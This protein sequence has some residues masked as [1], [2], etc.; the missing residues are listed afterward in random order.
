M[1]ARGRW[2]D[3]HIK[4]LRDYYGR[5][6]VSWIASQ[7]GRTPECVHRQAAKQF[8]GRGVAWEPCDDA[9]LRE[10]LMHRASRLEIARR[11]SVSEEE[12]D[13]RIEAL[14]AVAQSHPLRAADEEDFKRCYSSVLDRDLVIVFGVVEARIAEAASRLQLRKNKGLMAQF[15][16]R[17]VMPRWAAAELAILRVDYATCSNISIARKLGRSVKSV[18]S[19]A[20]HLGLQKS[21]E[22]LREMGAQN[23][24]RRYE[25]GA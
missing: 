6:A 4:F 13:R 18:V 9:V 21:P 10:G 2:A 20:H 22:R 25:R 16:V 15:G 24:R 12:L 5:R 17:T 8:T 7:L 14:R 1:A 23:V 19:K 11:L 3:G